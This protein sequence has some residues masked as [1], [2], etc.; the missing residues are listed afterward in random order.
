ML[1]KVEVVFASLEDCQVLLAVVWQLLETR[2]V[3]RIRVCV[4][5]QSFV[6]SLENGLLTIFLELDFV[7]KSLAEVVG[8]VDLHALPKGACVKSAVEA[9]FLRLFRL[10][11]FFPI[12]FA[13]WR[14]DIQIFGKAPKRN[15]M[16]CFQIQTQKNE[17]RSLN[18]PLVDFGSDHLVVCF[19]FDFDHAQWLLD[20]CLLAERRSDRVLIYQLVNFHSF[21]VNDRDQLVIPVLMSVHKNDILQVCVVALLDINGAL[22]LGLVV[23]QVF[24]AQEK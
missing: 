20:D 10:G 4:H 9:L 15:E 23:L 7:V 13:F 22:V 17:P 11:S 5:N 14:V 16:N 21:C 1:C 24:L 8:N 18:V 3:A 19:V 2:V 12:F 6:W